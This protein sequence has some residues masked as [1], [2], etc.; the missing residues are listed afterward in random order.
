MFKSLRWR[1]QVWHALVLLTVLASFGGLVHSLHWQTRLQQVDAELDRTAGVVMSQLRRLLP[2]PTGGRPPNRRPRRPEDG[3]PD[4]ETGPR[5]D[6]NVAA[7]PVRSEGPA[8]ADEPSRPDVTNR[9]D[10]ATRPDAAAR[11]GSTRGDGPQE[12]PPPQPP[13]PP[14]R[15]RPFGDPGPLPEEFQQ[16]FHGDEDSRLY[17]II[18]GGNGDLLQKSESAPDLKYPNMHLGSDGLP[19]RV[20]RSRPNGPIYREVIHCGMWDMNLLVGR[21]LEKDLTQHHRSGLFLAGLGLVILSAGVLGGGWLSAR[22]IQ[23]IADMTATAESI[24]AQNLSERIDVKDTD[25]ELGNLATVLN[26]TFDRLQAA[27]ERQSQF[28]A[29]ASHELRTPLSVIAT[30]TELALSRPR[31]NEDYRTAIETCRRASQRMK[32]L[33]DALLLL[34]RFDSGTPSLKQDRI[35]LEPLLR[36]C[37]ELVEPLA[38]QKKIQIECLCSPCH[39]LGDWDRLSQV[40]TNLMTNAIRYNVEGGSVQVTTRSEGDQA[41]I[42]VADTG[43]GIAEDQLPHIFDRFYQVDKARSRAEGSCGLGLSICKTI[44]EAHGGTIRASSQLEVGTTV[45]VR[46]PLAPQIRSPEKSLI[47]ELAA[48]SPDRAEVEIHG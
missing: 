8:R 7:T 30:H 45:E 44:V 13:G 36:D 4:T 1:L 46:L 27:F 41:I 43:V 35:D 3:N 12:N 26:R 21:S 38:T 39:V 24:S 23:P 37:A 29:D 34:A 2:R 48:V 5:T 15:D 25:T 28:A 40:V 33:I 19:L 10:A 47:H 16:L 11:P 32:S 14:R 9:P 20:A 22:A 31:S 17:F 42:A 6:S 18:W